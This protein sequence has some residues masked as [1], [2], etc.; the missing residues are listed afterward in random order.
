MQN[1]IDSRC[2][3][4]KLKDV[5]ANNVDK[6]W[7]IGT[8]KL[9]EENHEKSETLGLLTDRL[10]VL[11]IKSGISIIVETHVTKNLINELVQ[12]DSNA[13]PELV[14]VDSKKKMEERATLP[15]PRQ[16]IVAT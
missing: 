12:I 2:S 9:Q 14:V 8:L 7:S 15:L 1:L 5:E 4:N 13:W 11:D 10:D 3:N 16:H 6:D